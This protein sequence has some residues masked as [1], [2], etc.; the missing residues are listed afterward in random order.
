[1][2]S[3]DRIA[4]LYAEQYVHVCMLGELGFCNNQHEAV[5]VVVNYS[6]SMLHL[7]CSTE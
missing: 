3:H 6:R 5:W 1:M 2:E 4:W 7:S